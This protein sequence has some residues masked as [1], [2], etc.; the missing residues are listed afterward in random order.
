MPPPLQVFGQENDGDNKDL[1][2]VLKEDLL[3]SD[4]E[5]GINIDPEYDSGSDS[6]PTSYS[7]SSYSSITH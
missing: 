6:V 2:R 1:K 3:E 4:Q 5:L 7:L